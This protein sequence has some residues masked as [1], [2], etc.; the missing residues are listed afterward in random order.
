MILRYPCF[1]CRSTPQ[2]TMGSAEYVKVKKHYVEIKV[3]CFRCSQPMYFV[4]T[5]SQYKKMK[6]G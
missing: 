4:V 1:W 5:K 2:L 3:N 6:G